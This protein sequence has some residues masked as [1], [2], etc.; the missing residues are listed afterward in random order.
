MQGN[1]KDQRP[2][3]AKPRLLA[4]LIAWHQLLRFVPMFKK[5]LLIGLALLALALFPSL[6]QNL[7][8][9]SI[10]LAVG[11]AVTVLSPGKPLA[12]L[13]FGGCA[14]LAL[15][16][17][18]I[19][20]HFSNTAAIAGSLAMAGAVLTEDQLDE[21]KSVIRGISKYGDGLNSL[22]QADG[23]FDAL[24]RLPATVKELAQGYAQLRADNAKLRKTM[25][26]R[27]GSS[28]VRW[29]GDVP[30]VSDECANAL[31][32][33]FVLEC[34]RMDERALKTLVS[35]S[36]ARQRVLQAAKSFLGIE[37]R[38]ALTT[39]DIPVP[40]VYIPQIV[41]LVFK[42]GAARQYTTVYP[43]GA[44]TVKLPR[45][46]VGEDNFVYLGSGTGGMS[47]AVP[48]K[49]VTAELVQFDA[50]KCGGLIRI[51]TELEEDTFI[52]FGQFLARYIA[53][54][55]ARLEDQT[56]FLG[57]GSATYAGQ[58]GVG[59]YCSANPTYLL[60]LGAGKTKP[61][62]VTLADW[63]NL[64]A[65]VAPV[66][67]AGQAE[68]AYYFSPTFEP[69]LRSFNQYPNFIIFSN[70]NGKPTFDGWPVRWI[71]VGQTYVVTATPAAYIGFFGA[72]NY[73]FMGERGQP[74][75]E[76]SRDVFFAT[77]EL[78][79]RALERIDINAVGVD[80]MAALQTA[81]S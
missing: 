79:M 21:F 78:A 49:K 26:S 63:R 5:T 62:D 71:G 36:G 47:Q 15:S 18:A 57:D 33:V 77:D 14:M 76:V 24:S 52:Q 43:M 67:L 6:T 65:K 46:K 81:A 41:E 59:P 54:A 19:W 16:L 2:A 31:T 73:W 39:T 20:M 12:R 69:I 40:T 56:L 29:I 48:E 30:F 37:Q 4:G 27:D 55:F 51:P 34:E 7:F 13:L 23:G 28:G 70:E 60:Q 68:A 35:D 22:S 11:I 61:S 42:Y 58:I 80:A 10:V 75:I 9:V 45:L 72:L 53:R 38:A 74:R 32:S 66:I 50:N 17:A 1:C 64:R 3:C 44:G 25:L 8:A